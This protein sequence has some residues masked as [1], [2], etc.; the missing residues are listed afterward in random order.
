VPVPNGDEALAVAA[1]QRLG[2]VR[3]DEWPLIAA[4]LLAAGIDGE[5]IA[6]LA[7]LPR[8]ASG[9][10]VDQLVP[11]ALAEAQAP[12]LTVEQASEVLARVLAHAI[13]DTGDHQLIRELAE[14][15]PRFDYPGGRIGE[16]YGLS[17]YIDCQC[18]E[19]S[20][21][22]AAQTSSRPNYA[23]PRPCTSTPA[24]PRHSATSNTGPEESGHAEPSEPR[25]GMSPLREERQISE[26]AWRC[27][28]PPILAS[29]PGQGGP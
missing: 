4:F 5:G 23:P 22:H 14:F 13:P 19:G 11:V 29:E 3:S 7:G 27:L 2:S 18:H 26:S 28:D 20:S 17:E 10:E 6:T 12:D 24:S 15:A 9:W 21:D 1:A 25:H 16:A 8:S